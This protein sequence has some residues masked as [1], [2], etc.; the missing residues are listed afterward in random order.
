MRTFVFVLL[1]LTSL[2]NDVA[3]QTAQQPNIML[4]IFG[5]AGTGH[6]VWTMA[7]QPVLVIGSNPAQ[8]DTVRLEQ[9]ITPS[10]IL[11]A[12]ATYFPSPHVGLHIELSYLGLPVDAS[13][14]SVF[15]HP[16]I[17]RK[18]AQTC[19]DIR[20]RSADGG[21]IAI[22]GG[23]TFRAASRGAVSPYARVNLGFV[24][25]TRS[26]VEVSGGYVDASGANVQELVSDPHP[27][28]TSVLFGAAAGF[29]RPLGP[30]YQFRWEV[31]DLIVPMDRLL[32]PAVPQAGGVIGPTATRL[33]HHFS[34]IL[35]FDV[36]LEK[37]H[38]RRY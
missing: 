7:K 15:F 8:W 14:D 20:Q 29:T 27:R 19:D 21:S 4:T 38:G 30:G 34:M 37:K 25:E 3:A 6:S 5:G 22:F 32:Q 12:G 17:D 28:R 35:G 33:Y 11:G 1:A 18:N 23:A 26:T 24:N 31:R 2:A 13:C 36:V 16:D 10:I 9:S